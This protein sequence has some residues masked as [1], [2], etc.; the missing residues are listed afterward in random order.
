[1]ANIV[2][3]QDKVSESQIKSILEVCPFGSI[4]YK[5]NLLDIDSGCKMCRQCVKKYGEIFSL[6]AEAK[7][8]D[9][10]KWQN[11]AVY[12]EIFDG[13]IHNVSLELLGEARK[14]A[15]K[16]GQKVIAVVIGSNLL[17]IVETLRGYSADEIYVYDSENLKS[18]SYENY[19]RCV[20]DFIGSTHVSAMLF[21]ATMLGRSFAP[22]VACSYK[23]G[24]TADCTFLDIKENGD[25]VQV[26]PA[27]G[28]NIMAQIITAANRPQLATV[29]NKVFD[30]AKK[31][32]N[33][34]IVVNREI[35]IQSENSKVTLI[36]EKIKEQSLQI[37][38]AEV[39]I[40]VGRGVDMKNDFDKI[41]KLADSL[42]G[43]VACSRPMMEEGYFD[44]K[45]QIGLS[46]RTIKPKLI[47]CIGISGAIQFLVGM[48]N[49]GCIISINTD[50]NCELSKIANVAVTA[51]Y[52]TIIEP[53]ISKIRGQGDV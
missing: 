46:G 27:F 3:N 29:R 9:K 24:L 11:I 45:K 19:M 49:S 26:R 8:F 40:A 35:K 28:G 7:S 4:S 47:I 31:S 22:I 1:M 52:K 41:Q 2:I 30:V 14:L 18:F 6:D 48:Q 15:E 50:E 5:N 10:S 12:V 44:N 25:L 36:S 53:L 42:G 32:D 39:V 38:D 13:K 21:G 43:V 23:T 33:E 16:V 17:E 37:E 20:D 34:K 51:D